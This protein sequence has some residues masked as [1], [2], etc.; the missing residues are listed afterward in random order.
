MISFYNVLTYNVLTKYIIMY[1]NISQFL[2]KTIGLK[3]ALSPVDVNI[4]VLANPTG[5][6][7]AIPLLVF[8]AVLL[9]AGYNI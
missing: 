6:T 1:L 7:K 4:H 2:R 8:L 3:D 9:G 5:P